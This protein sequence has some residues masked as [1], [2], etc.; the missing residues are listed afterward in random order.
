MIIERS[1]IF[2]HILWGHH[3]NSMFKGFAAMGEEQ[4]SAPRMATKYFGWDHFSWDPKCVTSISNSRAKTVRKAH[5]AAE[6]W[7]T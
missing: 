5:Q 1:V 2:L 7:E 3:L 4:S 6:D